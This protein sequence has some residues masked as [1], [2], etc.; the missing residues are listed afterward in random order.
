MLFRVRIPNFILNTARDPARVVAL[1]SSPTL[2]L[3]HIGNSYSE[4]YLYQNV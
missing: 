2:Y 3:A 1:S 4:Y